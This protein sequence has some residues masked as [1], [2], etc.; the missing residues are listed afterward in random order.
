ML[1]ICCSVL[2]CVAVCCSVL[3]CVAVC[4]SVAQCVAVWHSV[5]LLL[6]CGAV[7]CSVLQCAT[8]WCSMVQCTNCCGSASQQ[9]TYRYCARGKLLHAFNMLQCVAV[10]CSVLQ[11]VAMCCS[12]AVRCCIF[13]CANSRLLE[14]SCNHHVRESRISSTWCML[15]AHSL[16][17]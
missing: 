12:V 8:A 10:C 17:M 5:L 16:M 2:Q 13:Q 14:F 11:C 6:Q 9:L 3:Q 1:S 4:C 15:H 7:C